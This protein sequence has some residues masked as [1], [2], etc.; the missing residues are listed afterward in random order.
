MGLLLSVGLSAQQK[1]ETPATEKAPATE[2]KA[3]PTAADTDT[4]SAEHKFARQRYENLKSQYEALESEHDRNAAKLAADQALADKAK[5]QGKTDDWRAFMLEALRDATYGLA[6]VH[7][8]EPIAADLM[9]WRKRLTSADD[10]S[11][12]FRDT[13]DKKRSDLTVRETDSV[14]GCKLL[15]LYPPQK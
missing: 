12:L 9:L 7:K 11:K 15:D 14:A 2:K 5:D 8:I 6:L 13:I 10:C 1:D 4:E 3:A